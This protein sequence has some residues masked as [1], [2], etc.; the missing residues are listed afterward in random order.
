MGELVFQDS[1]VLTM[2]AK[3]H[4]EAAQ[5]IDAQ[6]STMP[7]DV[8]GGPLTAL[9]LTSLAKISRNVGAISSW[10]RAMSTALESARDATIEDEAQIVESLMK[11]GK[12]V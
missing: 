1:D 6:A 11:V 12:N 5:N 4:H 9:V 3:R 2:M 8:D 10:S 7:E